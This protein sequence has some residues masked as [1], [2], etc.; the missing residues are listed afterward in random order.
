[1]ENEVREAQE[2]EELL[3][4]PKPPKREIVHITKGVNVDNL[5]VTQANTLAKSAYKM[6]LRECQLLH[7]AMSYI[8]VKDNDIYCYRIPVKVIQD[9]L[10]INDENVYREIDELTDDLLSRILK[11]EIEEGHWRK[12]QW[13]SYCEYISRE[14]SKTGEASLEIQLHD[15]LI[16][17]LLNLKKHFGGVPLK[18]ISAMSSFNS[19]RIFEILHYSAMYSPQQK[20]FLKPNIILSVADLKKRLGVGKKYANFKDFRR[21]VLLRAQQDCEAHTLL[22]FTWEEETE[23][24]KIIT[25][26]FTVY[27]NPKF[28]NDPLPFIN[29]SEQILLP[30][31][32]QGKRTPHE[33]GFKSAGEIAKASVKPQREAPQIIFD[34]ALIDLPNYEK[35]RTLD[36]IESVPDQDKQAIVDEWNDAIG[37]GRAKQR[38]RYLSHLVKA[39]EQGKFT[40]TSELSITREKKRREAEQAKQRV[41]QEREKERQRQLKEQ[42]YEARHEKALEIWADWSGEE[43]EQFLMLDNYVADRYRKDGVKSMMVL[44]MLAEYMAKNG[45]FPADLKSFEAWQEATETAA[46]APA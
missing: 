3:N 42:F 16:P 33:S 20:K 11:V 26:K 25:L 30:A 40:S 37:E 44:S 12:F 29:E 24:R 5:V 19:L 10:D 28:T 27:P 9:C 18:Q 8:R 32:P 21:E 38:W 36:I 34:S 35:K 6:T 31:V 45:D 14:K 23:G 2:I 1:M 17:M 46:L 7:L 22:T 43:Q 4:Q 41:E 39:Y 15:H 13:V